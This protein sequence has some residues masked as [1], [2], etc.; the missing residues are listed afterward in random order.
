M[1]IDFRRDQRITQTGERQQAAVWLA[2]ISHH[3]AITARDMPQSAAFSRFGVLDVLLSTTPLPSGRKRHISRHLADLATRCGEKCRLVADV[4]RLQRMHVETGGF[5][6]AL[7]RRHAGEKE[8]QQLTLAS[9]VGLLKDA[10][11]L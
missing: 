4:S 2:G 10:G 5:G 11:E 7:D 1:N 8:S 6:R 3:L 9:R